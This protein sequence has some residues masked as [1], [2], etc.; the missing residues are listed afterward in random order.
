[1]TM[2]TFW[3]WPVRLRVIIL[4]QTEV[5]RRRRQAGVIQWIEKWVRSCL[6]VHMFVCFSIILRDWEHLQN[7]KWYHMVG[8]WM[9]GTLLRHVFSA[10]VFPARAWHVMVVPVGLTLWSW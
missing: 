6:Y 9:I 8:L 7:R 4:F 10:V 1:M 3:S 2:Q 5:E